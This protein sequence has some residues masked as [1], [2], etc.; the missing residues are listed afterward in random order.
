MH[1]QAQKRI[2]QLTNRL[3]RICASTTN[4]ILFS[5]QPIYAMRTNKLIGYVFQAWNAAPD[6]T[7]TQWF[8][9]YESVTCTVGVRG[10]IN[11]SADDGTLAKWI[12]ID[13]AAPRTFVSRT[14]KI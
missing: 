3:T 12:I 14:R 2:L 7:G 9:R 4:A 6:G 13:K 1:T 8:T 5:V 11:V 10:K